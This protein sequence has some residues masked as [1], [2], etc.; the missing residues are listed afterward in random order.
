MRHSTLLLAAFLSINIELDLTP[1]LMRLAK[2][3]PAPVGATCGLKITGFRFVG[4]SA[5]TFD[6]AGETYEIGAEGFVELMADPRPRMTY[7]ISGVAVAIPVAPPDQFG[8]VVVRLP[9][10][11]P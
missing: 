10:V 4:K 8:F 6:Y 11:Q 7:R 3:A 2:Q 5:Q 1:L 9:V